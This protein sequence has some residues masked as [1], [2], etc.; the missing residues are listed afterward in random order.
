MIERLRRLYRS[1]G[2][3]E[4][5]LVQSITGGQGDTNTS[6]RVHDRQ[7]V[8]LHASD[9]NS[10]GNDNLFL[11]GEEFDRPAPCGEWPFMT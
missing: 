9:T 2:Y 3:F 4:G 5:G 10:A 1:A 11:V 8:H 6:G 7:S